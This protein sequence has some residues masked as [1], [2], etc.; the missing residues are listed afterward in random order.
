MFS[1]YENTTVS[2]IPCHACG[3]EVIEFAVPND[4]WNAVIR[5]DGHEHD[6]EYLCINCFFDALRKRIGITD[7]FER[8]IVKK[9]SESSNR[10]ERDLL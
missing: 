1:T 8:G 4:I 2:S 3:G 5:P 9:R 6:G 7:S 10:F